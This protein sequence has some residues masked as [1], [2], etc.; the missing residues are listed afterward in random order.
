MIGAT[1][2][3]MAFNRSQLWRGSDI[4]LDVDSLIG[5]NNDLVNY[6]ELIGIKVKLAEVQTELQIQKSRASKF[7]SLLIE[8]HRENLALEVKN[9][10]LREASERESSRREMELRCLREE[11]KQLRSLMGDKQS[12]R[13]HIHYMPVKGKKYDIYDEDLLGEDVDE[14]S[15]KARGSIISKL[16]SSLRSVE[17]DYQ[18]SDADDENE[19]IEPAVNHVIDN[20]NRLCR[21]L[22]SS[23][24][25]S[26][27]G[28]TA[29]MDQEI[30]ASIRS[31]S[32]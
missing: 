1:I 31:V 8:A 3:T 27:N 9:K 19:T 29:E 21:K 11:N 5:N 25:S 20:M 16:T 30:D 4:T 14:K 26:I 22:S 7:Q 17:N 24:T 32:N 28:L 12:K 2:Q 23:F 6:R 15:L 10:V 13:A 18:E